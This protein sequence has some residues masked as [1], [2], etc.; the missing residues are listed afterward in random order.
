MAK[1][2]P[3]PEEESAE[4]VPAKGAKK[5]KIIIIAVIVVAILGAAGGGAAIFLGKKDTGGKKVAQ[6][7]VP[8]V[9][10]PLE[11]F[12]VNLHSEMGDKYLQTGI[13]LQ[14]RN[15]Q[16]L[17]YYKGFMPQVRSRILLLLS[18]KSADEL[19]TNEGKLKLT[20][21]IIKQVQLPYNNEEPTPKEAEERRILGVFFTSFMIQ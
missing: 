21:E 2:A 8:A 13:T 5:K 10:L 7:S 4:V 16:Q 14:V 1:S 9:F 12:V 20:N 11:N 3:I 18:N 17:S 19:L 6:K 15:E